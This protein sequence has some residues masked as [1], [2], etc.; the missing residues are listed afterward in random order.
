MNSAT[1]GSA[2]IQPSTFCEGVGRNDPDTTLVSRTITRNPEGHATVRAAA[3][4]VPRPR[5]AQH[6]GE[7]D[8]R[9]YRAAAIPGPVHSAEYREPLSPLNGY[10]QPLG[11]AASASRH[12]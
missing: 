8:P 12:H 10:A 6:A 7:F 2:R 4:R 1:S 9:G 5:A 11:C 3:V